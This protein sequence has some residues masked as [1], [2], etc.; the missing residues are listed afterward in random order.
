MKETRA[1]ATPCGGRMKKSVLPLLAFLTVGCATTTSAPPQFGERTEGNV[2]VR[3]ATIEVKPDVFNKAFKW[4]LEFHYRKQADGTLTG[5]LGG[6]LMLWRVVDGKEEFLPG[7]TGLTYRVPTGYSTVPNVEWGEKKFIGLKRSTEKRQDGSVATILHGDIFE[8][9]I[10]GFAQV[11]TL[12]VWLGDMEF[13][14]D[15]GDLAPF[16]KLAE[17]QQTEEA[18]KREAMSK[19]RS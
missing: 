9:N 4:H 16:Q 18:R 2:V 17:G 10:I 1:H 14:L 3:S 7:V 12:H 15:G 5:V 13:Y 19:G 11:K 6:R 8:R